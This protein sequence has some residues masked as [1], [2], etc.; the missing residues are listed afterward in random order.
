MNEMQQKIFFLLLLLMHRCV[1]LK[2]HFESSIDLKKS[3]KTQKA[4]F[5]Y[6]F[7]SHFLV[8]QLFIKINFPNG[9]SSACSLSFSPFLILHRHFV[10]RTTYV[11]Q[12]S[13]LLI[14]CHP[15]FFHN[16]CCTLFSSVVL[17][18]KKRKNAIVSF[19]CS[20]VNQRSEHIHTHTQKI[21]RLRLTERNA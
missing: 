9:Y 2:K 7:S 18:K 5:F 13:T 12:S 17:D 10:E 20:T 21:Y 1:Y 19:L 16:V 14:Y 15:I 11:G 4:S 8:A 6:S 3:L